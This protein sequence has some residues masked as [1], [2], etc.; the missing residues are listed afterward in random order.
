VRQK[1][2]LC[3]LL[4]VFPSVSAQLLAHSADSRQRLALA[5]QA[6]SSKPDLSD[7]VLHA[8]VRNATDEKD[9]GIAV[10]VKFRGKD[11]RIESVAGASV[12]AGGRVMR[13]DEQGRWRS[14]VDPNSRNR[15]NERIPALLLRDFLASSDYDVSAIPATEGSQEHLRVRRLVHVNPEIDEKLMKD[16]EIDVFLDAKTNLVSKIRYS[17][18]SVNDWRRMV[19]VEVT[20]EDYREI[21]GVLVPFKQK[22]YLAGQLYSEMTVIDADFDTGLTADEFKG[23]SR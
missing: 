11:E 18:V 14:I 22:K 7:A 2:S 5:F 21:K 10:T 20:Y 15:R 12:F 4:F 3:F 8:T 17:I 13:V 1:L 23:G 19:E 6:S 16:S 9:V